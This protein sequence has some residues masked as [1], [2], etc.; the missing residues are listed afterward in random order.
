MAAPSSGTVLFWFLSKQVGGPTRPQFGQEASNWP[1]GTVVNRGLNVLSHYGNEC[2][3]QSELAAAW[4]EGV[5][6]KF[7]GWLGLTWRKFAV[8]SSLVLMKSPT[9]FLWVRIKNTMHLQHSVKNPCSI[10]K[11]QWGQQKIIMW[12][13]PKKKSHFSFQSS[14]DLAANHIF[15]FHYCRLIL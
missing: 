1:S 13:G 14:L 8:L 3:T 10:V 9:I 7:P 6:T 2:A 11:L 5:T 15:T 12:R 4:Q